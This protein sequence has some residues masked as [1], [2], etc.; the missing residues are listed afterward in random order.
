ME[1]LQMVMK[2]RFMM[3]PNNFFQNFIKG[4]LKMRII[5]LHLMVLF[6]ILFYM[7]TTSFAG[8]AK[9]NVINNNP[10]LKVI[11]YEFRYGNIK[12]EDPTEY[13]QYS[14]VIPETPV[15]EQTTCDVKI[16]GNGVFYI[17]VKD[18]YEDG[19]S[20]E[21]SDSYRL[22]IIPKIVSNVTIK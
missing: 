13:N 2:L 12:K 16:E 7:V 1:P 9:I 21:Y 18:F 19:T 11:K 8:Y 22:N 3:S 5:S 14:I 20:S 15:A 10:K 4:V 6:L 17:S